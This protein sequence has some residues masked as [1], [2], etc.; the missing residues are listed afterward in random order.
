MPV[1]LMSEG[2][3]RLQS[4]VAAA[5]TGERSV[6]TLNETSHLRG[7]GLPMGLFQEG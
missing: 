3:R 6:V 5:S 4:R 1:W 7:S 2:Y